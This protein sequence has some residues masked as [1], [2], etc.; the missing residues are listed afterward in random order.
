MPSIRRCG[1][2]RTRLKVHTALLPTNEANLPR[3]SRPVNRS[4]NLA[5]NRDRWR[6]YGAF[7]ASIAE[8]ARHGA[9]YNPLSERTIQNPYPVYARLRRHSPVHRSVIL[10]SWILSRYDDVLA[11]A[12]DHERFSNDPRWRNATASVLPPAPDDYSIL[13]VDPP[14]HTRLRKVAARAFTRP[15]LMTLEPTIEALANNIVEHA[16]ERGEVEWIGEVAQ[17]MAMRVMLH[18]LGIA[19]DEEMRWHQWSADRARLL[20]MIATRAE[21][22]TAHMTGESMTGY[23]RERLAER[24]R[25]D[26]E[27]AISLLAHEAARGEFINAAEASD[28]LGVI[29][30]AGNETTANLIGNGLWALM[31]H[32]DQM[33]RLREEPERA[34][35]AINEVLRYDSPVQTDFRIA[36]REAVVGGKTIRSGEGVILLTGSANRDEAAFSEPDQLDI[37][38]KGPKHAAFGHGVHQCIGA[39]LARMETS[40]VIAAAAARIER[41]TLAG[42]Q[43]RY[44][45]STVVRGLESLA[46]RIERRPR[47]ARA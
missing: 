34:R 31:R 47:P 10:G 38:R 39:E 9:S 33:E 5:V 12:R 3:T 28:M 43:P 23:F 18:M 17:P 40:A 26:S 44:R 21:R 36:K 1:H 19:G 4:H 29:M 7:A 20:D 6:R 45:H 32:P 13:L 11:V 14:E 27:D 8:H 2:V 15:R 37:A 25:R 46:V 24:A 41:I 30:I 35:D 22:K 16:V 42:P